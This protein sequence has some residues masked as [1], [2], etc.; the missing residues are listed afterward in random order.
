MCVC[1]CVCVHVSVSMPV[2]AV[3]DQGF[4]ISPTLRAHMCADKQLHEAANTCIGVLT[5]YMCM[6]THTQLTFKY[7]VVITV[8]RWKKSNV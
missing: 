1:V 6:C 4:R 5:T 3:G 7:E 2:H 8:K